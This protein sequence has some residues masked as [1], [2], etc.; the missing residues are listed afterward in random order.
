MQ[1]RV[2]M[3]AAL[4]RAQEQL[5]N[6]PALIQLDIK[7]RVSDLKKTQGTVRANAYL[8][9]TFIERSMPHSMPH[10][11]TV[12]V[13]YRLDVMKGSTLNLLSCN[14]QSKRW[15]TNNFASRARV[16]EVSGAG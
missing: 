8:A 12:N 1:S 5:E 6:Q 14:L 10:V 2:Q 7:R 4:M 15:M 3:I 13:Q 11:E 9:K 16:L